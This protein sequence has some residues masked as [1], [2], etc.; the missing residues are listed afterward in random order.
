MTTRINFSLSGNVEQALLKLQIRLGQSFPLHQP[1]LEYVHDA[2]GN[3]TNVQVVLTDSIPSEQVTAFMRAMYNI[4]GRVG[5]T[6]GVP[7]GSSAGVT[8]S[9]VTSFETEEPDIVPA[10]FTS[11]GFA[12]TAVSQIIDSVLIDDIGLADVLDLSTA[13]I[14]LGA[15]S[16]VPGSVTITVTI[17][18]VPVLITD[19]GAG[20]L[21]GASGSL[22]GDGTI[23]YLTGEMTGTTDTLDASSS[24]EVSYTT[25]AGADG[26][27]GMLLYSDAA[28]RTVTLA[29][30][31]TSAVG[32]SLD[33][34]DWDF[35]LLFPAAFAVNNNSVVGAKPLTF[36][37]RLTGGLQG[38]GDI[39]LRWSVDTHDTVAPTAWGT[40]DF[41][42]GACTPTPPAGLA[43]PIDGDWANVSFTRVSTRV[44]RVTVGATTQ[45]FTFGHDIVVPADVALIMTWSAALDRELAVD[46]WA[47]TY[48]VPVPVGLPID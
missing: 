45:D 6:I 2:A 23:D 41:V 12:V 38:G 31:S 25:D 22:P 44:L 30:V 4:D 18:A 29:S 42:Q 26:T 7:R 1:V 14:P 13:P 19:D 35:S 48:A 37:A 47:F 15:V 27:A 3:V 28:A 32:S 16:I 9:L 43:L 24:V 21:T 40:P 46:D 36:D 33:S 39:V 10:G 8:S 5:E 34:L 11:S 17:G 20:V